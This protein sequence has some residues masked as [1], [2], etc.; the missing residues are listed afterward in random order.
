LVVSVA[1]RVVEHIYTH[2][3]INFVTEEEQATDLQAIGAGKLL[4]VSI[5]GNLAL[6]VEQ[7]L[8]GPPALAAS[9]FPHVHGGRL[10]AAKK[11]REL[12][13]GLFLLRG[14]SV[15]WMMNSKYMGY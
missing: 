7:D 11:L 9:G 3:F 12:V 14:L 6:P 13:R 4:E 1:R 2:V 5:E 10:P 8:D 15:M